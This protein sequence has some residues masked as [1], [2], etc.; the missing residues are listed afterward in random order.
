MENVLVEAYGLAPVGL[1]PLEGGA[2]NQNVLVEAGGA[3]YVL[4]RYAS[5]SYTR[6]EIERS[7]RAQVELG[8][9][10]LPVAPVVLN[11][12]GESITEA[13]GASYVLHGYIAGRHHARG[14]LPL[15]AAASMGRVHGQMMQALGV[16]PAT[17]YTLPSVEDS[18]RKLERILALAERGTGTLDQTAVA[19][20]RHKIGAVGRL[21]PIVAGVATLGAQ[22]VHGDYQE[23]NVLFNEADQV[24]AVLDFDNLRCRPRGYDV[25]RAFALCFPGA[26]EQAY[27]Y[28][29]GYVDAFR[30]SVEEVSLYAPL[31]AYVS[32]TKVWPIDVR[33]LEPSAYQERWDRF[34]QPPSSWW[35]ENWAAVSERLVA[36]AAGGGLS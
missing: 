10:G 25:M 31:W 13:D 6:S 12:F 15:A 3:R 29:A 2:V 19:V 32:A 27:A 21:A 14:Q 34:I 11:R 23:T 26:L 1:R 35:E 18:V 5:A 4:K 30:P 20:L 24:V 8:Q 7:V 22:W 9:A 28:F 17:S 36:I 33:Y 16:W